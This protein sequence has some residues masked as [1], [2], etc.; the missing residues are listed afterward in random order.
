MREDTK[1]VLGG[2]MLK[3]LRPILPPLIYI[4]IF[5]FFKH[6]LFR[7][8]KGKRGRIDWKRQEWS[9]CEQTS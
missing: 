8:R 1:D 7:K 9:T 6:L 4:F 3:K 2:M 5:F